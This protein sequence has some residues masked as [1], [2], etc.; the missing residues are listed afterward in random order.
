MKKNSKNQATTNAT[1]NAKNALQV[2]QSL[3]RL[4]ET[5][6]RY[7]SERQTAQESGNERKAQA[8]E[9]M[10]ATN[11]KRIEKTLEEYRQATA[12]ESAQ[13][14][15]KAERERAKAEYLKRLESMSEE[16]RLEEL[17]KKADKMPI[18]ES[19]VIDDITAQTMGER[20]AVK[21]IKT[22]YQASGNPF[23]LQ[24]Y[25]GLIVDILYSTKNAKSVISDGYDIAQIA[26]GFLLSYKGKKLSE[27]SGLLNKDGESVTI[28]RACFKAVNSYIMGERQTSY[29]KV[30]LEDI[31][32]VFYEVPFKWDLP[33]IYD[34][35]AVVNVIKKLKLSQMEKR[36]LSMRMQGKSREDIATLLGV[37]RGNVN[38]YLQR[39]AKKVQAVYGV[40]ENALDNASKAREKETKKRNEET[41]KRNATPTQTKATDFESK[42]HAEKIATLKR[43]YLK[44]KAKGN[45]EKAENIKRYALKLEKD[46]R[47]AQEVNTKQADIEKRLARLIKQANAP[48]K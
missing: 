48:T 38:T 20:I 14:I 45:E 18:N 42:T 39:I 22:A 47:R 36:I 15:L 3:Q 41:K 19:E 27:E 34:Y 25:S 29:K 7:E 6:K 32:G 40:E 43:L 9:K 12:R 44:A 37:A 35:K 2:K 24:L 13:G 33:T 21:A 46:E 26:I 1:T 4:Q 28:L 5:Q 17:S 30:Y 16:E 31:E 11:A 23:M 8:Y 10:L